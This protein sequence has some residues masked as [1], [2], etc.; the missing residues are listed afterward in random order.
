MRRDRLSRDRCVQRLLLACHASGDRCADGCGCGCYHVNERRPCFKPPSFLVPTLRDGSLQSLQPH[1]LASLVWAMAAMGGASA[2]GTETERA[3]GAI[4]E[5]RCVL[6]ASCP[7]SVRYLTAV[8]FPHGLDRFHIACTGQHPHRA[9]PPTLAGAG[10]AS[11]PGSS[12]MLSGPSRE[13]GIGRR[14]WG[15]W[16]GEA[17]CASVSG[18]QPLQPSVAE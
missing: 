2:F 12:A 10:E 8:L 9:T 17:R 14:T 16:P 15:S 4:Q 1:D 7:V 11:G 5:Q 6:T 13:V 3:L 18:C